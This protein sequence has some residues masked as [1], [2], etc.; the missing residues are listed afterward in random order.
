MSDVLRDRV[1][2]LNRAGKWVNE[3]EDGVGRTFH[4]T[5]EEAIQ[6]GRLRARVNRTEHVVHHLDGTIASREPYGGDPE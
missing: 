1:H 3:A 5:R 2:T 6:A 4:H